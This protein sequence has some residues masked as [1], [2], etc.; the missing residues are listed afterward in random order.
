MQVTLN[1][2]LNYPQYIYTIHVYRY[3]DQ[4]N[5]YLFLHRDSGLLDIDA[6][7]DVLLL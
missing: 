1:H 2:Y 3:I 7:L 4:L 6:Y 5:S